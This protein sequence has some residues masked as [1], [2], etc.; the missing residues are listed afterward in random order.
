MEY[1]RFYRLCTTKLRYKNKDFFSEFQ[2]LGQKNEY[3][4]KNST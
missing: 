4:V 3:Y 2:I 1:A